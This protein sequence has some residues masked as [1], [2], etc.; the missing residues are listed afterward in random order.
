M[1]VLL[2]YGT[3]PLPDEERVA[4]AGVELESLVSTR[5]EDGHGETR[6][7]PA[8]EPLECSMSRCALT[9]GAWAEREIRTLFVD[10]PGSE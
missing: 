9:G 2:G 3:L 4:G 6:F 5:P 8:I 7:R 10:F 1:R